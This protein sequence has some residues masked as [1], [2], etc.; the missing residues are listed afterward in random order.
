[1]EEDRELHSQCHQHAT[2]EKNCT[3]V[4]QTVI[5]P[6][7]ASVF[8]HDALLSP[9]RSLGSC[10]KGLLSAR[11]R[12]W[13]NKHGPASIGWTLLHQMGQRAKDRGREAAVFLSLLTITPYAGGTQC[14]HLLPLLWAASAIIFTTSGAAI[15]RW[16]SRHESVSLSLNKPIQGQRAKTDKTTG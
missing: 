1:M 3:T 7:I 10:Q 13:W 8:Y 2:Y 14:H 6:L 4:L 15:S 11:G 5:L 9:A 12:V 16:S